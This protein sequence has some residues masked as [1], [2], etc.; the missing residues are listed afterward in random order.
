MENFLTVHE[1][2]ELLKVKPITVREM[3]R[4]QRLRG[5][6][7]GKAWRTTESMLREDLEALARGE[8]PV[9]RETIFG[10]DS[11]RAE[12]FR[13]TVE[14]GTTDESA[15]TDVIVEPEPMTTTASDPQP[16]PV[17]ASEPKE[18]VAETPA[19]PA[20]KPRVKEAEDNPQQLLF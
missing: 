16:A 5:F 12:P 15:P 9:P 11:T 17:T 14:P 8:K 1:V 4:A 2:A 20:R 6:K 3:F 13:E 10:A 7:M 19:K 18:P